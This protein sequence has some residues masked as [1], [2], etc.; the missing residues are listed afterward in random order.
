MSKRL[1]LRNRISN[2]T[3]QRLQLTAGVLTIT[4]LLTGVW[5]LYTF[6][7]NFGSARAQKAL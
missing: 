4:A 5:F 3:R 7:G 2:R 1:R 6:I